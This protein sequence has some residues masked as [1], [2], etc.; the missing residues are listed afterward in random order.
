MIQTLSISLFPTWLLLFILLFLVC[1]LGI[2]AFQPFLRKFDETLKLIR[3]PSTNKNDQ[4][5]ILE[6]FIKEHGDNNVVALLPK[7]IQLLEELNGLKDVTLYYIK[8]EHLNWHSLVK[9]FEDTESRMGSIVLRIKEHFS[10]WGKVFR[11]ADNEFVL[12]ISSDDENID[13]NGEIIRTIV[14]DFENTLTLNVYIGVTSIKDTVTNP[15]LHLKEAHTAMKQNKDS[16]NSESK[17]VS[18]WVKG[19]N[20]FAIEENLHNA[21]KYNHMYVVYQPIVHTKKEEVGFEALIR[22]DSPLFGLIP[23]VDFISV[24]EESGFIEELTSFVLEN[25][26]NQ[27]EQYPSISY[28]TINLSSKL[29]EK[30]DWLFHQLDK[31]YRVRGQS[32]TAERIGF[33]LTESMLVQKE[34][35]LIIEQLKEAGHPLFIDDFGTGFSSISYLHKLP[36]RAIKLDRFFVQISDQEN[37]RNF[38]KSIIDMAKS[39]RLEVVAEGVEDIEQKDFFTSIGC[40]GLQGFLESKPMK[41]EEIFSYLSTKENMV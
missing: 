10:D 16:V 36:V 38:L 34:H 28:I 25:V 24:A 4:L 1:I 3:T 26:A 19:K 32:F 23:P 29:F 33:E 39:L 18:E 17:N 2:L 37:N 12:L 6:S 13:S 40:D 5:S 35:V 21:I 27:L 14:N 41:S 11:L 9:G 15:E 8:I 20:L 7:G 30:P 22:W 31:Q